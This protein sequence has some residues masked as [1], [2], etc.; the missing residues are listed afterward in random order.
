[1]NAIQAARAIR[2]AA[3][4]VKTWD[5]RT[6]GAVADAM[7]PLVLDHGETTGDWAVAVAALRLPSETPTQSA[8]RLAMYV[9]LHA[10]RYGATPT[11]ATQSDLHWWDLIHPNRRRA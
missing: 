3:D 7:P 5:P 10:D 4:Q 8:L 2:E 6:Y 11:I 9:T 1:M